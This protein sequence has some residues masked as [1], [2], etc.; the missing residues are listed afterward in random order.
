MASTSSGCSSDQMSRPS[1]SLLGLPSTASAAGLTKRM[2]PFSPASI[3]ASAECST[4]M[5]SRDRLSSWSR[6]RAASSARVVTAADRSSAGRASRARTSMPKTSPYA[7]IGAS[8]TISCRGSRSTSVTPVAR[9]PVRIAYLP[10]SSAAIASTGSLPSSVTQPAASAPT[11][12]ATATTFS[13][14]PATVKISAALAARSTLSAAPS[15]TSMASARV[16]EAT[17]PAPA[18]ARVLS[19]SADRSRALITPARMWLTVRKS[20]PVSRSGMMVVGRASK[21]R[22]P[23]HMTARIAAPPISFSRNGPYSARKLIHRK[24][25]PT[26]TP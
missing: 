12:P 7:A 16:V 10:G 22:T 18:E 1:S 23:A 21:N 11:R 5:L 2:K 15:V 14:R 4:T 9:S 19:R 17:R 8:S 24:S 13:V 25:R 20:T 26:V 3:R 6:V